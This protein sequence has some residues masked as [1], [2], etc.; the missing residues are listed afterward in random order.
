MGFHV[1]ADADRSVKFSI[2]H[3]CDCQASTSTKRQ[4]V[5]LSWVKGSNTVRVCMIYVPPLN[6]TAKFHETVVLTLD[7]DM[8]DV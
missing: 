1:S 5:N 2:W 8:M 3:T 7:L 4:D 6:L